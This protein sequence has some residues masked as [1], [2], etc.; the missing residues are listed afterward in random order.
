MTVLGLIVL[1]VGVGCTIAGFLLRGR[2]RDAELLR[3]LD[4]DGVPNEEDVVRASER[5]GLLLPAV[6]AASVLLDRMDKDRTVATRLERAHIA[7]RS[8]EYAMVVALIA[9]LAG[10]WLWVA[11]GL[12]LLGLAA[13]LVAPIAGSMFLDHK[14]RRR[15]RALE[16]ELPEML[17]SIASSVRGG[18]PLLRATELLAEEAPEPIR[19]ELE[20][21]LAE[22]RL[23]V[24]VVDA[25]DR[26]ARRSE[27]E[28][29]SWVVD[30]IRIQQSVG[31]KL[32]DLLFTLAEHLREREE[33][34]REV[35]TL[36]AEGRLSTWI[37][38][39][40]PVAML[41]FLALNNPEYAGDLFHGPGL[42]LL[43][44]AGVMVAVG[45]VVITRMVRKVVL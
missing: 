6:N 1:A 40:L 17:G 21:V 5:F 15:R 4:V 31:G 38:G 8:G 20:R 26:F 28:D 35:Q 44:G 3:L 36:T 45:V 33:I 42:F 32:A 30:A 9:V 22:T 11:T 14:V 29:L 34:R 10:L 37:L 12:W 19:S 2:D 23:G 16:Q 18:H 39:G 41:I 13:L 25:F 27:L 43:L 24:S 7:L